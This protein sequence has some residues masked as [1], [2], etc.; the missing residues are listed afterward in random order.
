MRFVVRCLP[1]FAGRIPQPTPARAA[2]PDW[3]RAMPSAAAAEALAG[4][5]VRTLKHCPPLLDAM[6]AG[7]LFPLTADLTVRDGE[8]SWDWEAPRHPEI[9]HTRSPVGVHLPEQ[10]SGAPFRMPPGQFVVKFTNFWTVEV[11]PGWSVLF[12]HPLNREDLPF[13]T[14]SGVVDCDRWSDGFV[15]F[16]ALW[17]DPGFAG[18]LPAGTPVAQAVPVRREAVELVVEEMDAGRT[19]AHAAV[20]AALGEDPGVYRKQYRG[21]GR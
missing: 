6:G 18:T 19:A 16:P 10:A 15:H 9:A 17:T 21:D 4:A 3:L 11:P 5:E 1:G 2:L 14:L 12:T 20:E 8:L 13:R 7:V